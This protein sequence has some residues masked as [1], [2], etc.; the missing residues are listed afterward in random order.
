MARRKISDIPTPRPINQALID[1]AENHLLAV[2]YT[3]I[4]LQPDL[5][6]THAD[7]ARAAFGGEVSNPN[8][9]WWRIRSGVTRLSFSDISRI[10]QA[11][12]MD[13]ASM[14]VLAYSNAR[15]GTPLP[16][17]PEMQEK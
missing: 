7:F 2:I 17:K 4:S 1:L 11:I 9:K 3:E 10:G 12:N 6:P 14:V 13:P 16:E 5:Y 15:I 8:N